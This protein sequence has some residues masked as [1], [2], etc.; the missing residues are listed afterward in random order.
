MHKRRT[1][2]PNPLLKNDFQIAFKLTT[3]AKYNNNIELI[4]KIF[5]LNS[6][7]RNIHNEWNW[8][9]NQ[10]LQIIKKSKEIETRQY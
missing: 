8:Y 4:F 2:V 6:L 7:I 5:E 3:N 9:A 10:S 1:L